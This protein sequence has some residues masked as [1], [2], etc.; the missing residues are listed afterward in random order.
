MTKI[1]YNKRINAKNIATFTKYG[2]D[3]EEDYI[4]KCVICESPICISYSFSNK[5]NR[6]ICERCFYTH[7]GN[8]KE[9]FLWIEERTLENTELFRKLF[10]EDRNDKD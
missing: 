10:A 8:A 7:F 5:G 9:A 6:L 4:Y 3:R 2:C 1:K